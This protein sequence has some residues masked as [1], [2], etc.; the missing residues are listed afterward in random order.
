MDMDWLTSMWFVLVVVFLILEAACPIHLVSIWFAA[1]SLVAMLA[2]MLSAP[3][4]LQ[5]GFFVVISV[6]LLLMLLPWVKK[7]MEIKGSRTN[8]DAVIGTI[9]KVLVQIDNVCAT[10]QVKLGAM[11][12]SARSTNG[13]VIPEGTLVR[14]DRV[15]GVKVFVTPAEVSANL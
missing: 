10:G 11:E 1:G 6:G 15:E 7:N 9:G 14:V 8:V 4:W 3:L 5:I 2:N 12:W 13:S